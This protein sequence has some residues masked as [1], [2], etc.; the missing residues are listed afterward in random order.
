MSIKKCIQEG[1]IQREDVFIT[2]KIMPGAYSNPDLAIEDSLKKLDVDY[3]DLM[4]IHQPG[5]NDEKVYESM[6]KYFPK[7]FDSFRKST[8]TSNTLPETHRTSFA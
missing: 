2:S 5:S 3:I 7:V 1:I 8:A 4:L 6:E